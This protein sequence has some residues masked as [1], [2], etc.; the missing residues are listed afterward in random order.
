MPPLPEPSSWS[1]RKLLSAA[2]AGS[3]S[4]LWAG[5]L[6]ELSLA[7]NAAAQTVDPLAPGR[8]ISPPGQSA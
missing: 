6:A 7:E 5:I 8:P 2:L 1:R 4:L 3:G